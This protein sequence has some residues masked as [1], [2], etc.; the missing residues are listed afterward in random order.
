MRLVGEVDA[1]RLARDLEAVAAFSECDPAVGFSRPTFSSSWR[2]ARDYV[3]Q[4][5]EAAGCRVRVDAAGNVHARPGGMTWEQRAWLCGSHID[6]VPTGGKFDGVTGVVAALE[7]LR[8][9][10][11][12]PL[13]L[14]VFAEEE[15]TTFGLGMLGSK[16]WAG[17][18]T[19]A[20]LAGL[21]NAEGKDYLSAG[22]E[23]GV[24]AARLPSD[25]LCAQRYASSRLLPQR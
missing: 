5:A 10:P 22:A 18:I 21:R 4:R 17:T 1:D 12:A 19:A 6:S 13:E 20:E 23:H 24:D 11:R 2:K 3:I 8:I 25:R 16:A 15:G 14:I 7:L 9:S